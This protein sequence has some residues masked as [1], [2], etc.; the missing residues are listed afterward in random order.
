MTT[1]RAIRNRNAHRWVR[2]THRHYVRTLTDGDLRA[3]PDHIVI[4]PDAYRQHLEH[5]I[6]YGALFTA[7]SE[8]A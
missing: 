4:Y 2:A 8:T 7:H 3:D 6:G 5:T 1:A